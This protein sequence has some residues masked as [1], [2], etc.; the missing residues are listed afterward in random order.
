MGKLA[1]TFRPLWGAHPRPA[2]R[3]LQQAVARLSATLPLSSFAFLDSLRIVCDFCI[4]IGKI[5]PQ[6]WFPRAHFGHDNSRYTQ[7][8]RSAISLT[9]QGKRQS[10]SPQGPT[11][12]CGSREH[13][14]VCACA[15]V[16]VRA[17][18]PVGGCVCMRV[19]VCTCARPH[20]RRSRQS[21][22]R[23]GSRALLA[24]HSPIRKGQEP[25]CSRD[26][27]TD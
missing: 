5:A 7:N 4:D 26:W 27:S 2:P 21:T 12:S 22:S 6:N 1:E 9:D 20:P 16:C 3:C 8:S 17:C 18:V 23:A 11:H 24:P 13:V 25:P 19:C 14:R 15:C 10:E